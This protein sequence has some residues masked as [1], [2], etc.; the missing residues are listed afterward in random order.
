MIFPR[1]PAG[2]TVLHQDSDLCAISKPSGISTVSERWDRAAPTVIDMLWDLWRIEDASAPRPHVVHR[3]DKGTS[4]VLLFAR[5]SDSQAH[6][7]RQFHSREVGKEYLALTRGVPTSRE[8]EIII[9]VAKDPRHPG[10]MKVVHKGKACATSYRVE[11]VFGEI[12]VV[13]LRPRTGRTHQIRISLRE[14]GTPCI[15]D[16][17]YGDGKPLLLSSFKGNYHPGRGNEERPLLD[18]LAL[19]ATRL[20]FL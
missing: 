20:D 9:E 8:G 7:R 5:H 3:L 17:F 4:G 12:A 18:R 6:L 16:P 1:K 13:R 2:I 15:A 14:A 19:H 10:R 11:E